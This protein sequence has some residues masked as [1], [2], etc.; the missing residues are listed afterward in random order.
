[1]KEFPNHKKYKKSFKVKY[2]FRNFE[3]NNFH[4]KFGRYGLQVLS[5]V[6]LTYSQLDAGRRLLKKYLKKRGT[7]WICV[8]PWISVT[9]KPTGV[10]MGKGKGNK[11]SWL[12]PVKGGSIIYEIDVKSEFLAYKILKKCSQKMSVSCKLVKNVY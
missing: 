10:R 7:F 2:D 1:M 11:M 9:K 3:K 12:C 8:A 4:L 6:N 5:A